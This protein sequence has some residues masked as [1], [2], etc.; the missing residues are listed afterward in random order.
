MFEQ[1]PTPTRRRTLWTFQFSAERL[2]RGCSEKLTFHRQRLEFW[3]HAKKTAM[4][5]AKDKGIVLDESDAG[6][7]Y[8][9]SG[10]APMVLI[11]QTFQ[12]RIGEAHGKIAEHAEKVAAY[13]G[14]IQVFEANKTHVLDLTADDYLYFFGK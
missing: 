6:S 11:D 2:L 9:K 12:N 14:W 8:T 3:Q 5:E 10:R 7:N 4:A 13:E 1:V